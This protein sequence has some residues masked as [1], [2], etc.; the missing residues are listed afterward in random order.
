MRKEK[1]LTQKI[2]NGLEKMD[3]WMSAQIGF[4]FDYYKNK[5]GKLLDDEAQGYLQYEDWRT[6]YGNLI[7]R[8]RD[9][10]LI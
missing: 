2:E 5:V 7:R 1:T 6:R 9:Q 10:R 3:V 4:M 8:A